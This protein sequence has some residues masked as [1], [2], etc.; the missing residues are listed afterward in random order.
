MTEKQ[1]K[2]KTKKQTYGKQKISENTEFSN[3]EAFLITKMLIF[4]S[5]QLELAKNFCISFIIYQEFFHPF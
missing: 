4:S 1:I 2:N 3:T 5:Q